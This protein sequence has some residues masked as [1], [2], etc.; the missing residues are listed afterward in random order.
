LQSCISGKL[1]N[2]QSSSADRE[3]KVK[4]LQKEVTAKSELVASYVEGEEALRQ[5]LN[6]CLS[7]LEE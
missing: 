1:E 7:Q 5:K 4:E 6:H 2:E 3:T